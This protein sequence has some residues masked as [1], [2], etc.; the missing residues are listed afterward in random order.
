MKYKIKKLFNKL[1]KKYKRNNGLKDINGLKYVNGWLFP[2]AKV[3]EIG[4]KRPKNL[5]YDTKV[6]IL[7]PSKSVLD[8]DSIEDSFPEEGQC[9]F[10]DTT[11]EN[12][13]V[14]LKDIY[15]N[16]QWLHEFARNIENV[17]LNNLNNYEK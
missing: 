7:L 10:A 14:I 4:N 12:G 17:V 15:V 9:Y 11:F 8:F 2:M 1:F 6:N 5:I 16:A 3:I 13:K